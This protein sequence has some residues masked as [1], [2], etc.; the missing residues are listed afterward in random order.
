MAKSSFGAGFSL[1]SW[2]YKINQEYLK[3]EP[4][5]FSFSA[6]YDD[7]CTRLTISFENRS[8]DFGLSDPIQTFMFR[9]QFKPFAD[10]GFSQALGENAPINSRF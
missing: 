3:E 5:K 1:G 2:D 6:I 10:L 9:V 4:E 7:E 8:A